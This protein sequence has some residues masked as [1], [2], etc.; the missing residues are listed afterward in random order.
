MSAAKRLREQKKDLI[1]RH[2]RATDLMGAWQ[3]LNTLA[4]LGALWVAAIWS[5]GVSYGLTAALIVL[6]ILFNIRAFALLHDCGHGSL[7]RSRWMN[8]SAGFGLGVISGMPQY[9]W[10]QHHEHHHRTNGDWDRYR[11]PL[12]I[13]SVDEYAAL[14]PSQQ[15][16]YRR[17]R[18]IAIA[19]L[20]G[21][22]YLI[23]NPRFTWMRGSLQ[24]LAHLVR[25]K[26]AQPGVSL[27]DHAASFQTRYWASPR[28]YWHMTGNNIVL[29]SLWALMC[30]LIGPALFFLIY[31]T[32]VSLAG[33]AGMVLFTVQHN[34]EN[35]YASATD[36][37]SYDVGT[38]DG[39]SFLVLPGWLNW[40]TAD[41]A[42]H[43]VHHMS[44]TIPNYNLVRCH[45]ENAALFESVTRI[46]LSQVPSSLKC[47]LWDQRT[48]RIISI[49]TA[50]EVVR[51]SALLRANRAA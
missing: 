35:A 24:L 10:S 17:S 38:L 3:L 14:S 36:E 31:L 46:R 42:Y 11:G 7:F 32:S 37:W 6:L 12:N 30:W 39:T 20:A 51:E 45:R 28:Q 47:I 25:K 26:I 33:G 34:F 49:V 16:F 18:H 29:L 40:F 5:T 27:R 43:H 50:Q 13:L 4:P 48:R 44:A 1:R 2:S 23:F 41:I 22:V 8:R 19:P 21:F 9:V 15:K